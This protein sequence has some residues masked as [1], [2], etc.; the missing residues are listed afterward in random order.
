MGFS[1]SYGYGEPASFSKRMD[2]KRGA[3]GPK[4]ALRWYS[5]KKN[6]DD[7]DEGPDLNKR[8]RK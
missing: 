2:W 1:P 5:T 4:I 6:L 3:A 7:S 8:R